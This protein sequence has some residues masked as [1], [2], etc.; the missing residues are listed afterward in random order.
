MILKKHESKKKLWLQAIKW[1]L[2]SV[3]II[4]ILLSASFNLNN[5]ENI[6]IKNCFLFGIASILILFWE[7][8]TNDLY[9]S[10]TGIDEFKFHSIVK[11][12]KNKKI[13]SIVAYLSLFSGLLII[14]LISIHYELNILI[15]CIGCCILGYLYQG[16]PFR[17]GY[18]GLGEPLCFIAFGPLTHAAALIA[19]TSNNIYFLIP[20]KE[21]ILL[22]TGPSLAITLV[23]FCSHFHQIKEDK[24]F[25]KISPLVKLGTKKGALLV[26]WIICTIYLFEFSVI[27]IGFIPP[28]CLLYFISFPYALKLIKVLKKSHHNPKI[29]KNCKFIAIKFHTLNGLGLTTGLITNY[30]IS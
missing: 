13:I 14:Y 27:I 20:W 5:F 2:Y 16:P 7:N 3:V 8:L 19:T 26:P 29:I 17:L 11:L 15:I 28:L 1:P 4:P 12:F 10:E 9:D 18:L 6:S 23:L 22:G 30:F 25:G 21:S 24:K